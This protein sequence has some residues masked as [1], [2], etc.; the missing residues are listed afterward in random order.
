MKNRYLK[1][2]VLIFLK[3]NVVFFRYR[4][5]D[6]HNNLFY[7]QNGEIVYHVAAVGIVYN[8]DRHSQ[9]F[10]LGHTDD[11]LCL[12]IHPSKDIVATGQVWLTRDSCRHV[13]LFFNPIIL[14]LRQVGRDPCIHIWDA[15]KLECLS[16]LKGQHQRGVCAVDFSG[17]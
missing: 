11:I 16:I 8:R 9:R 14:F 17:I 13:G 10:Y 2:S 3:L 6:C 1:I 7:L 4:G 12:A 5:Y 15:E